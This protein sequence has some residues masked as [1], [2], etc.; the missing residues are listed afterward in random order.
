MKKK[1]LS[2]NKIKNVKFLLFKRVTKLNPVK[3]D[4]STID[5]LIKKKTL[6]G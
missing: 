2:G 3:Q 1:N 4:C 5:E 6:C